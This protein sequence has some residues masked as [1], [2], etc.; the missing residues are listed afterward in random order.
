M[1]KVTK[2]EG[3]REEKENERKSI[4]KINMYKRR[5]LKSRGSRKT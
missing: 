5:T 4:I 1:S 3:E 2:I